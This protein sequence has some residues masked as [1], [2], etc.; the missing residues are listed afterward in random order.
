MDLCGSDDKMSGGGWFMADVLL[1][2]NVARD[3]SSFCFLCA[4]FLGTLSSSLTPYGLGLGVG[5]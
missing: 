1:L 5:P 3:P 2:T 4:I